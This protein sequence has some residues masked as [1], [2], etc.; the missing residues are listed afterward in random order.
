MLTMV[1]ND[2]D[3][4][5]E[6]LRYVAAE[7]EVKALRAAEGEQERIREWSKFWKARDPTPGTPENELRDEYYGRIRYATM[8][9]SYLGK[10]GWR[11][12]FGMVYVTYGPP[13]EI[14][15]HP[16]DLDSPAYQVW[17]Y[18]RLKRK[19]V[20]VDAGYGEYQL[21]Y[22]YDGDLRKYR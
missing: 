22:P 18:Y 12:D 21:Q 11:T 8:T 19:F 20:F 14:D 9:F 5:V 7:S 6:Q 15:R 3:T 1:R 10:E 2:Y 17:Y 16:F 4:A 13:D